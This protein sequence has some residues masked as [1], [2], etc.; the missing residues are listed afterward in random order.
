MR[1]IGSF[2]PF[3]F[4]TK[5]IEY[6]SGYAG[7][8]VRVNSGRTAIMYAVKVL[9][10]KRLFLPYFNCPDLLSALQRI[11]SNIVLYKLNDDLSPKLCDLSSSDCIV[12]TNY[13]GLMSKDNLGRV[14]K[15]GATV[16]FD[17]AQAFF[18]PPVLNQYNAYSCRKF[19][20]VPDGGYLI[21]DGLEPMALPQGSS[22]Q[23]CGHLFRAI[24]EGQ[25]SAYITY[26]ENEKRIGNETTGMSALT[27]YMLANIDYSKSILKRK[28]N[29]C[30]LNEMLQE[31]NERPFKIDENMVPYIY[32]LCI[33]C[34]KLRRNLIDN[35]IY[36]SRW[37]RHVLD[38]LETNTIEW[39]L[40]KYLLPLPIDQRYDASDME[41]I[42]DIVR[43][44][45]R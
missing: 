25:N 16:I 29:Y 18:A 23:G 37:W 40:A 32:P 34:E 39:R 45:L 8:M 19:F 41:Y 10:P 44:G 14:Q 11:H 31:I 6:Y 27:K 13:F 20:G 24:D 1:E 12:Y 3:E 30:A 15:L 35:R 38:E 43:K 33:S 17:N 22:W 42:A 9:R 36:V 5:G 7:N 26:L 28:Q 21:K 2:I 4:N